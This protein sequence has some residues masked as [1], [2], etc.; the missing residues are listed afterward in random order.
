MKGEPPPLVRTV[1]GGNL[2]ALPITLRDRH[3]QRTPSSQHTCELRQHFWYDYARHVEESSLAP[4][5]INRSDPKWEAAHVGLYDASLCTRP[6]L[7]DGQVKT[8]HMQTLPAQQRHVTSWPAANVSHQAAR[9][10]S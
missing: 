6:K 4:D 2:E 8:D 5:R 10:Y 7:A 1:V 9:R 3:A